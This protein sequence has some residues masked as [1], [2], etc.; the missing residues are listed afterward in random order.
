MKLNTEIWSPV[1]DTVYRNI[2]AKTFLD[3]P[4]SMT[5]ESEVLGNMMFSKRFA[6]PVDTYTAKLFIGDLYSY[7][8]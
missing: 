2:E 3:L 1:C 4:A 5:I 7:E 8:S 6:F